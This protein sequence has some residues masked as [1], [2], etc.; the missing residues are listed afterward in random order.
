M[1]PSRICESEK[2]LKPL[3]R[4]DFDPSNYFFPQ[5]GVV[6]TD[7]RLSRHIIGESGSVSGMSKVKLTIQ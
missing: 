7:E 1:K 6:N 3:G 5:N 4:V 2:T